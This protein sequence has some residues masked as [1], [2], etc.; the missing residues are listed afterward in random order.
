MTAELRATL[1]A[2]ETVAGHCFADPQHTYSDKAT[3]SSML[4]QFAAALAA[5]RDAAG[6]VVA[7]EPDQAGWTRRSM[8]TD[9]SVFAGLGIV[10]VVGFF[11]TRRHDV[12][13][14]VASQIE[15]LSSAL[16]DAIPDVPGVY[17]YVTQLLVDEYNYANLVLVDNAEVIEAWRDTAP[18]PVAA[19]TVS[20]DYYEHVR[21]YNGA[22][23]A[24]AMSD[25]RALRIHCV[26]YWDFRQSPPWTAVREYGPAAR[27]GL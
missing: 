27:R 25:P 10:T 4:Q 19:A 23:P 17:A 7:F 5:N 9:P 11:G 12:S 18:H 16:F 6:P 22:V 13:D 14:D 20:P 15:Q 8:I 26:K 2:S 3:L 1:G 21:I 24:V